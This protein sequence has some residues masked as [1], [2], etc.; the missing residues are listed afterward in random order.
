M[1]E[2]EI[3]SE[4]RFAAIVG[5]SKGLCRVLSDI[6]TVAPTDST[7][8]IHG[9]TGTG[10]ELIARAVHDLSSRKANAFERLNCAAG[11]IVWAGQT[12][13]LLRAEAVA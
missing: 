8:L 4:F 6:E 13:L 2:T 3:H 7:V 9:E 1:K 12:L 5:E 10:K 11:A